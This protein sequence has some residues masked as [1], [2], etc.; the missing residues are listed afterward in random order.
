MSPTKDKSWDLKALLPPPS[1]T[2]SPLP[3]PLPPSLPWVV[4]GPVV[5]PARTAPQNL[6]QDPQGNAKEFV[7]S[8]LRS[9]PSEDTTRT[10][11]TCVV[12]FESRF[13]DFAAILTSSRYANNVANAYRTQL[14][15]DK[16][17]AATINVRLA[18]LRSFVRFAHGKTDVDWVL[19]IKNVKSKPYRD[20]RGPGIEGF[21]TLIEAARDS[22]RDV[23]MMS[24]MMIL[25]LR[26]REIVRLDLEHVELERRVLLVNRKGSNNEL[27]PV[28]FPQQLSLLLSRWIAK[29]GRWAGPL[30]TGFTINGKPTRKRLAPNSLTK[31]VKDWGERAGFRAWCHGLRH[32]GITI[33]LDESDGDLRGGMKYA[34]HTDVNVTTRYDDNRRVMSGDSSQMVMDAIIRRRGKE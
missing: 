13:G 26:R 4:E 23:A 24:L 10:Y 31:I 1:D 28:V 20:T 9:H 7:E 18:A 14:I 2:S 12:D 3:I 15:S 16:L 5:P 29:R 34:G 22:P 32:T 6:R 17:A 33:F 19:T 8:W 30:F 27:T 25:A 21:L 11:R